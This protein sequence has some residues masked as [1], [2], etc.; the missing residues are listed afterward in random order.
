LDQNLS[1]LAICRISVFGVD[2]CKEKQEVSNEIASFERRL[3]RCRDSLGDGG[4]R[5]T[6]KQLERNFVL[7][8]ICLRI[9]V[10]DSYWRRQKG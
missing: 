9:M 7:R 3:N 10:L 2:S 8:R 5:E 4:L 6:R 1:V